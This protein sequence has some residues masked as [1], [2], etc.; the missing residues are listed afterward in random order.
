ME[1]ESK[2]AEVL[3]KAFK[4]Q[5]FAVDRVEDGKGGVEAIL[6]GGY[7]VV[8]LDVMLP[9]F[10]GFEVLKRI[11]EAGCMV[12]VL[13]LSAR[14]GVDER[15]MGLN[16]GADDYLPKPFIFKE[17]LAR[18]RAITRR[19]AVMPDNLLRIADLE[20]DPPRHEVRRAG[21]LIELSA[22]EFSL[23][24]YFMRRKGLVLTRAMILDQVW[25]SDYFYDGG[26][27]LVV[28]FVN[29]LRKKIDS[30]HS[31]KLIHTVRGVGYVLR[32]DA[33]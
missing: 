22:R 10:D 30:G 31:T 28:V 3:R 24:E 15:V 8:I 16:L 18:I 12:P 5:G 29:S 13:M 9:G 14:R 17:V 1:D 23:L 20:L 21:Y 11:R 2:L 7:D 4:E 19:P 27:N 6:G 25:A 26:S 33:Q 32:E